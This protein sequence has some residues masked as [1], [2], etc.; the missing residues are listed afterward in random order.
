METRNT[1]LLKFMLALTSQETT[2]A[3]TASEYAEYI[4]TYAEALV[5]RYY[6]VIS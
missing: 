3:V 2:E 4:G 1:L 6:E 5:D